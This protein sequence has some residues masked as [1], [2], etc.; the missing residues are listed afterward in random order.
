[1]K[2]I[3]ACTKSGG[4][5]KDGKMPWPTDPIDLARFKKLTLNSTVIMGRGTWESKGM[6]KPLPDRQNIVASRSQLSL[7]KN[8]LQIDDLTSFDILEELKVDWCIGGA[9]LFDSLFTRIDEIHLT[10]LH[11][12]YDCDTHIDLARIKDEFE[13]INALMCVSHYYEIWIRK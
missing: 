12:E 11:K 6:P 7:P 3:L 13:C 8:V 4:I 9:G 2:A 1:V 5:G 10:H